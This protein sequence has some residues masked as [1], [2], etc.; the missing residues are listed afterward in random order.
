MPKVKLWSFTA[1]AFN[2]PSILRLSS[3][4]GGQTNMAKHPKMICSY[5]T[6]WMLL[7]PWLALYPLLN[8]LNQMMMAQRRYVFHICAALFL[9][10]AIF[11]TVH[12]IQSRKR[13]MT[14]ASTRVSKKPKTPSPKVRSFFMVI[15][16]LFHHLD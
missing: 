1:F 8:L 16:I 10:M 7:L 9:V 5:K 4:Y 3:T 14:S 11:L 12:V 6:W 13:V 15:L 2:L